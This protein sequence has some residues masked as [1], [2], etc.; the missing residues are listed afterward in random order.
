M[1]STPNATEITTPT[2]HHRPHFDKPEN[3]NNILSIIMHCTDELFDWLSLKELA[4]LNSTCKKLQ[5]LTSDYVHRK[6]PMKC[7]KVGQVYDTRDVLYWS[8]DESMQAFTK[9]VRNLV[10]FPST[11]CFHYLD[12]QHS[13]KIVSLAFYD[14]QIME[15]D[16][17][18]MAPLLENVEIIEIQ[19]GSIGGEFYENVLK[20][21]HRMKQLVIKYGFDECEKSGQSNQWVLK[22]YPTLEHFHWSACPLPDNLE[23][24]FRQNPNIRSFN[25]GVYTTMNVLEFLLR[26]ATAINELHFDLILELYEDE[27]EGMAMIQSSLNTL[28]E[29][30]QF[31]ELMLEFFFC[32]QLLDGEWSTLPYLTGAYIDFSY[33]PGST[34]ALSMLIHLKLLILGINTILSPAKANTLSKHLTDLE[35]IYI[36]IGSV[37]AIIPFARNAVKLHKIYVYR[38][39]HDYGFS[40]KKIKR[41]FIYL[42]NEYRTKLM[43]ACKLII[44]LPDRAYVQIK[45]QSS[46]CLNQNLIEIKRSE[47]HVVTHPFAATK[48]RKDICEL[49]EKF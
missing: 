12:A 9:N 42:L 5:E 1:N 31:K 19:Y 3:H 23:I 33:Q 47:S 7:M 4:A 6:Y 8:K 2:I 30:C 38:M 32:S 13:K 29:R 45:C 24:F 22:T 49:Y 26:T 35:E 36:Q 46:N 39:G 11:E 14:G 17:I 20:Y 18:Y 10:V 48:I 41:H 21:C 43:G 37:H 34:K 25:S 15:D 28:Y 44:Y 27:N 16:I 40:T